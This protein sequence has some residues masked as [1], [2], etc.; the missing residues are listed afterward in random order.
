MV[1]LYSFILDILLELAKNVLAYF[2]I[3][4]LLKLFFL[5]SSNEFF[6]LF[7]GRL[8][9]AT[10]FII[11]VIEYLFDNVR[12]AKAEEYG[13]PNKFNIES[14]NEQVVNVTLEYVRK[15]EVEKE[16]TDAANAES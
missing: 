14:G 9:V 1:S 11:H 5:L 10:V 13:D 8:R 6:T 7:L 2:I 16:I 15:H 12:L 3:I 4:N